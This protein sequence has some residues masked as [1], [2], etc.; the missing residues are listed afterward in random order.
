[1]TKNDLK[2]QDREPIEIKWEPSMGTKYA[3]LY[4]KMI[5]VFDVEDQ[6]EGEKPCSFTIF[7]SVASS[8]DFI[9]ESQICVA[10]E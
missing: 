10:D 6:T 8:F 4:R 7:D 2:E 1:M 5:E 9:S 3:I